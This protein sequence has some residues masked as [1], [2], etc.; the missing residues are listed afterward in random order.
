MWW[1]TEW[2][3]SQTWNPR[4]DQHVL[5]WHW[6]LRARRHES[7]LLAPRRIKLTKCAWQAAEWRTPQSA[8]QRARLVLEKP[9]LQVTVWKYP[10]C[11]WPAHTVTLAR[12]HTQTNGSACNAVNAAMLQP[13]WEE[14]GV[15]QVE[16]PTQF[17]PVEKWAR[18]SC[19]C[20][21]FTSNKLYTQSNF[22]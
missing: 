22:G 13:R 20:L 19:S 5:M 15:I 17:S 18:S 4:Q 7:L 11:D 16:Q 21:Q 6:A 2:F 1:R 3:W 8:C 14:L 9:N 12:T 10:R